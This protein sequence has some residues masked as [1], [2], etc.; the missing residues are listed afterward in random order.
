MTDESRRGSLLE[1]LARALRE[2]GWRCV[3]AES[4]TGGGVARALTELPGSSVWFER[5]FVTYS[6]ESKQEMLGVSPETIE[7]FGAVSEETAREMAEGA[8]RH[9][10]GQIAVAVSGV[11]GP[12]GGSADKPVGTVV[13]A[14]AIRD[15]G[16]T[17]RVRQFDGGRG[18]IRSA[19]VFQ[20]LEGL[21]ARLRER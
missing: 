2:R 12:S 5:G 4:C 20:A 14:W 18:D 19:S 8:L 16:T 21:L 9:G 6:N 11:A 17:T 15:G 7:R 10:H 13:F 1:D 3:T